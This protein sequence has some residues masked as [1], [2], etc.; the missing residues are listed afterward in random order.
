[1]FISSLPI[2]R[3]VTKMV[4][5][6]NVPEIFHAVGSDIFF[7]ALVTPLE[8]IRNHTFPDKVRRHHMSVTP[9]LYNTLIQCTHDINISITIYH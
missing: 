3:S 8:R 2:H 7:S 5:D 1:M 6:P 9:T 4:V